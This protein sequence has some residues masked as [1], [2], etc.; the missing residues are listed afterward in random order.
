MS[1]NYLNINFD[2][3]LKK[4]FLHRN[5]LDINLAFIHSLIFINIRISKSG[6]HRESAKDILSSLPCHWF[7]PGD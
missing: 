3:F 4:L 5:M 7:S 2:F 6:A 1:P